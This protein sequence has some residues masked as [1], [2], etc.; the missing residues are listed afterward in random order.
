VSRKQT[1]TRTARSKQQQ[2]E[3]GTGYRTE[4]AR[5][6]QNEWYAGE[7][8]SCNYYFIRYT[9]KGT[10]AQGQ[11][12]N[13]RM[14]WQRS[15]RGCVKGEKE[16]ARQGR[17]ILEQGKGGVGRAPSWWIPHVM[18]DLRQVQGNSRISGIG[19]AQAISQQSSACL[20]A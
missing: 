2:P 6:K 15:D 4:G 10:E 19:A 9:A 17:G 1:T 8:V 7:A 5:R 14:G 20:P 18:G 16:T 3:T 12:R 13:E 11:V